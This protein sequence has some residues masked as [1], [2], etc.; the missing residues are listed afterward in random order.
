[1]IKGFYVNP[2][3]KL[4][5]ADEFCDTIALITFTAKILFGT[6]NIAMFVY[7][8]NSLRNPLKGA[9]SSTLPYHI[10]AILFSIGDDIFRIESDGLGMNMYGGCSDKTNKSPLIPIGYLT[11]FIVG[12]LVTRYFTSKSLPKSN[13]VRT[14]REDFLRYYNIYLFLISFL[15]I[16]LYVN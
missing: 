14:M 8:V 15:Y 11:V 4:N 2:P 7:I 3:G 13:K 9:S 16:G 12:P 5:V 1:M 6:Y 10:G